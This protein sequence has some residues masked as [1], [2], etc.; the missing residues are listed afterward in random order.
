M[1][2]G[3]VW[4]L[5]VRNPLMTGNAGL[6]VE[7]IKIFF[8]YRGNRGR[9]LQIM[10]RDGGLYSIS[11]IGEPSGYLL[12]RYSSRSAQMLPII[13]LRFVSAVTFLPP[14]SLVGWPVLRR[15][16]STHERYLSN[17]QIAPPE[18]YPAST[19]VFES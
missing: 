15:R 10:R 16:E 2:D 1:S 14:F 4:A 9:L 6:M 3:S 5:R 17:Y 11:L 7:P 8:R 18:T 13:V 19:Y 12:L